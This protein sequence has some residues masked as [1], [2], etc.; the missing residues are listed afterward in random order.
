MPRGLRFDRGLERGVRFARV[1]PAAREF[2][3]SDVGW[4]KA[5]IASEVG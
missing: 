2:E 3:Q 4:G 5:E 1:V